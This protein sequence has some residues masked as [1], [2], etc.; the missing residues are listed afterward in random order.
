MNDIT[1]RLCGIGALVMA[2]VFGCLGMSRAAKPVKVLILTGQ[3]DLPYH[4]W[5]ETSN[6]L[7]RILLDTGRFE[8]YTN[9]EA[10]SIG[11][12]AFED[13]D[14]VAINYNGQRWSAVTESAIEA[15]VRDGKGLLA[16][17]QASY[18]SF[19]G[20]VFKDGKW[21]I[22][23][24]GSGW[25]EFAKMIGASWQPQNIGH[26]RRGVF[27]AK[28]KDFEHPI[29]RGLPVEF[30]IDDEIYHRIDLA[31]TARVL[32]DVFSPAELGGTGRHEPVIWTN[33]YG[34]GRIFFT[35]LGHDAQAFYQ[36]GF[37]NALA[38]GA[39]WVGTGQ[40]TLDAINPHHP[41]LPDQT[42]HM[43]VVTGGHSYPLSFYD[44]LN[45]LP[46]VIWTHATSQQEAFANP[47]DKYDVVLLHDMH[48]QTSRQTRDRLR[49]FVKAGKGVISLHHSIVDYTDWPWWYQQVTGGKY[50]VKATT[51]HGAGQ[52][53]EDVEFLVRPSA[54]REH[55]PVL[56]GVNDLWVYDE[57]YSNMWISPEVEVLMETDAPDND[58][59]VVYIGPHPVARVL[60]VQ[61]GHS[62]HTMRHPGFQ[63]LMANAVH[64][65][66]GGTTGDR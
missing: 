38:R 63:R 31:P 64:W 54:G 17:H 35:T 8:V 10:R 66:T 33:E 5:R 56:R 16:F 62:D 53:I 11:A 41:P 7:R 1:S 25:N 44:M 3:S 45:S 39:E 19:F 23:P 22:G 28:W 27:T 65:V 60:Y 59:P 50:F 55:H 47:L 43:L 46:D 15:S 21:H 24:A 52:Y 48:E 6:C 57:Q 58:K 29:S 32:A 42:I 2:L 34:K 61:L 4:H 51:E 18:G 13:Y 20:H 9:E 37:I 49:A 14:L 40:V 26:A 30:I 12:D 36:T